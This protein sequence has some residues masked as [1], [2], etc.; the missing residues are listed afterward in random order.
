M[1][2]HIRLFW[3]KPW[4]RRSGGLVEEGEMRV[5]MLTEGEVEVGM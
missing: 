5:W 3:G 4:M 2:C 1:R